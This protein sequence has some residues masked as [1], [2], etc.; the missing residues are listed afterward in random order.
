MKKIFWS[1]CIVA[2]LM[3]CFSIV[4]YAH[5]GGT[6]SD[7]G[8]WDS[9]T[10]EYHYHHGYSAHSHYDIDGDGYTDCPYEFDDKT[11]HSSS[12][13]GQGSDQVTHRSAK[14]IVL[15]ILSIIGYSILALLVG[16]SSCIL[17]ILYSLLMTPIE[18]LIKKHCN[19]DSRQK[20]LDNAGTVI[21][22]FIVILVVA[23]VTVFTI[24]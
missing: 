9:A 16:L 22:V 6:D 3:L 7:G 13:A 21:K 14:D 10:G 8:H 19:E 1:I 12:E 11:N 24:H 15:K 2:L 17:P 20:A 5:S 23:A 4:A 18:A